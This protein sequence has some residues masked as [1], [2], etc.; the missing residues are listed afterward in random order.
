M[1]TGLVQSS[2]PEQTSTSCMLYCDTLEAFNIKHFNCYTTE[3]NTHRSC[4]QQ[5]SDKVLIH[6]DVIQADEISDHDLPYV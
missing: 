6:Q 5:P 2:L 1:P 3:E 4:E